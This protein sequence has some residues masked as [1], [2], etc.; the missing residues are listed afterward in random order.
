MCRYDFFTNPPGFPAE[1]PLNSWRNR[2]LWSRTFH[3][4]TDAQLEIVRA[5]FKIAP[6]LSVSAPTFKS[7]GM[8]GHLLLTAGFY[9]VEDHHVHSSSVDFV[10]SPGLLMRTFLNFLSSKNPLSVG[11]GLNGPGWTAQTHLHVDKENPPG[12]RWI[13]THY[14]A[15]TYQN[16][17]GFLLTTV[18]PGDLFAAT[19]Y[20]NDD[21]NASVQ[22]QPPKYVKGSWQIALDAAKKIYGVSD[23]DPNHVQIL[24]QMKD[25]KQASGD[26]MNLA[27]MLGVI[28]AALGY[29]N[30]NY[31]KAAL[32]AA[33]GFAAGRVLEGV[34]DTVQE[35]TAL[36]PGR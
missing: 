3:D 34:R 18:S 35:A 24:D 10:G 22:I 4:V 28:G 6:D 8:T 27:L 32:Y 23:P 29:E 33:A 36:I 11:L 14:R 2:D 7:F 13:E 5:L 26:T 1:T 20:F 31:P 17:P 19:Q 30:K 25:K 9:C 16:R 15:N 21:P 12:R